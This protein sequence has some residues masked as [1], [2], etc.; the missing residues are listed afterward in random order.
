[1]EGIGGMDRL[2]RQ[3]WGLGHLCLLGEEGTAQLPQEEVCGGE[4]G[5]DSISKAMEGTSST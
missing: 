5:G 1:M 4:G 3:G 2:G